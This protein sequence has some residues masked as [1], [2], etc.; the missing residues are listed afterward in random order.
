MSCPQN[1]PR[2]NF[3]RSYQ[4]LGA[5][6]MA[7]VGQSWIVLRAAHWRGFILGSFGPIWVCW[8]MYGPIW[9]PFGTGLAF[10]DMTCLVLPDKPCLVLPDK[11]CLVLP[12]ETCRR[13]QK[14]VPPVGEPA[15][16]HKN[17]FPRYGSLLPDTTTCIFN[18][19]GLWKW[20]RPVGEPASGHKRS[21]FQKIGTAFAHFIL[22]IFL[23]H[24]TLRR[25]IPG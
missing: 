6:C 3:P 15:A 1:D 9:N 2:F 16:G 14:L 10:P 5:G 18:K 25:A 20:V 21:S 4:L 13:T 7:K 24:F 17:L 12:D 11:T 22:A 8:G 19:Q 23:R